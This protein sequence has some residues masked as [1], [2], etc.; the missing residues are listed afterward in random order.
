MERIIKKPELTDILAEKT[1]F[2]KCNMKIVVDALADIVVEN[3]RTATLEQDSEFH[4]APGVVI[5]GHRVPEREAKD[6]R[7]GEKIMSPEK[8]IPKAVFKPSVRLK[9]YQKPKG[10]KKKGKK[11]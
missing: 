9:L 10:Y 5:I 7:T 11:V 3:L 4:I 8:V 1:G 6:P 2:F